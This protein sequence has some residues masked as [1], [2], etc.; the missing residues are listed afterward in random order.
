MA[1]SPLSTIIILSVRASIG[2]LCVTTINVLS[3]ANCAIC[4]I[5]SCSCRGSIALVGSSNS[6]TEGSEIIAL[7]RAK[8]CFCPPDNSTPFSDKLNDSPLGSPL[9]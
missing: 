6:T 3:F 5:K 8:I 9:K 2:F 1:I 4:L 7:V